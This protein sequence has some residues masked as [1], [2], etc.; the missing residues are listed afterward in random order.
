MADRALKRGDCTPSAE[1]LRSGDREK[2]SGVER[3]CS[4]QRLLCRY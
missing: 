2:I 3:Q 1:A 4:S